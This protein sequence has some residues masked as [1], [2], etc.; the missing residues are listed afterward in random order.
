MVSYLDGPCYSHD[1]TPSFDGALDYFRSMQGPANWRR[2]RTRAGMSPGTSDVLSRGSGALRSLLGDSKRQN[3]QAYFI[4]FRGT[5]L[6]LELT[7][8]TLTRSKS[9]SPITLLIRKQGPPLDPKFTGFR[10]VGGSD[11][12]QECGKNVSLSPVNFRSSMILIYIRRVRGI[13]PYA[14]ATLRT[15]CTVLFATGKNYLG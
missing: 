14:C 10:R 15:P 11:Q 13:L 2:H 12:G 3:S 4:L 6:V 9:F 7:I 1:W 5:S 8:S